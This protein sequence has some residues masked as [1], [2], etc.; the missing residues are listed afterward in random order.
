MVVCRVNRLMIADFHFRGYTARLELAKY[1]PTADF[2]GQG[3][4]N[5]SVQRIYPALIFGTGTPDA[6]DFV[7]VFVK[8]HAQPLRTVRIAAVAM[9]AL[10]AAPGIR[11]PLHIVRF[12]SV[13][14]LPHCIFGNYAGC[15]TSDTQPMQR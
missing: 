3:R 10:H 4:L 6:H 1:D 5:T 8:L 13:V 14:L 9:V 12:Y 11:Y 2:V 15:T 7:T